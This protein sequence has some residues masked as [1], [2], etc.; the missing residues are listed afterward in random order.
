MIS[1]ETKCILLDV[2]GVLV[3]SEMFSLQYQKRFN[4]PQDIMLPFFKG[5]FQDCLIGKADL[6][7]AVAPI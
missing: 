1:P 7:E 5:V 4:L 6:K 3:N 2:D